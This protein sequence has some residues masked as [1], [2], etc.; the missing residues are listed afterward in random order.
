MLIGSSTMFSSILFASG[1]LSE[2]WSSSF[3]PEANQC[4]SF[5]ASAWMPL[6]LQATIIFF[7]SLK[8]TG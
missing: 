6:N 7:G 8:I 4:T 5:P 2:S 1:I 3:S